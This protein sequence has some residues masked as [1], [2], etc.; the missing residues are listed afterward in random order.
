MIDL[1]FWPTS[2]GKKISI[3]LE[4]TGLDYRIIP[5]NIGQ[6]D[7]FEESFLRVS[8]N[9]KI[10]AIVDHDVDGTP[11]AIFESGAILLYLAEKT[12]KLLPTALRER[13]EVLQWL[14]W[15]IGGLGPIAGQSHFFLRNAP[16]RNEEAM[17]RFRKETARLYGVMDRQLEDRDYLAG[18]YSI[19]D[20]A[21]WPWVYRHEW[22]QQDLDR[23]PNVKGWFET[24]GARPAVINGAS[25]GQDLAAQSSRMSPEEVRLLY[26]LDD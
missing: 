15:Q 25:V 6:G 18:D 22:Q 11:V 9:N 20:I 17:N 26:G 8:P 2:N 12:Q 4:E 13:Y 16:T 1:Y 5:I 23:F 21:A 24:V 10:P 19:A 7:Q 14:F 3:M